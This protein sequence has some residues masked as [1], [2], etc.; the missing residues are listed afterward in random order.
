[1]PKSTIWIAKTC[2][3][4]WLLVMIIVAG[5][6]TASSGS[7]AAVPGTA[8]PA[9]TGSSAPVATSGSMLP[10]LCSEKKDL[11]LGL[12]LGDASDLSAGIDTVMLD[13][14]STGGVRDLTKS[15]L[16]FSAA[17][18]APVTYVY[19]SGDSIGTFKATDSLDSNNVVTSTENPNTGVVGVLVTF[20]VKP[21]PA[22]TRFNIIMRPAGTTGTICSADLMTPA[23]IVKR[24]PLIRK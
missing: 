8:A 10:V 5:C 3:T 24:N 21:L 12:C 20:R 7:N 22:N 1:M 23:L 14:Y 16:V 2:L 17:G 15:E 18:A 6:S 19:G 9:V 4:F 11:G 13:V